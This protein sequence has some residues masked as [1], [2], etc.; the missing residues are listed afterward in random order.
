[1]STFDGPA[2]HSARKALGL[3]QAELAERLGTFQPVVSGWESG[4]LTIERPEM[5]ALALL[6]LRTMLP[7]SHA[8]SLATIRNESITHRQH[9]HWRHTSSDPHD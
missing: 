2:L 5:L 3:K 8:S 9:S 1:M 4:K 6:G 7:Q